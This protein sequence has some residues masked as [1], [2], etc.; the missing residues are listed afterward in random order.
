MG[1]PVGLLDLSVHIAGHNKISQMRLDRT[2][3]ISQETAIVW[4]HGT[5][6]RSRLFF[7]NLTAE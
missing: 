1:R 7:P 5:N 4:K 3:R 6:I 2:E